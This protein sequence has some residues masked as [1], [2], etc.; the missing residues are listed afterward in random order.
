MFRSIFDLDYTIEYDFFNYQ[1]NKK[2]LSNNTY[3]ISVNFME[4]GSFTKKLVNSKVF[5]K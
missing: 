3:K 5:I 1:L 4:N 2:L